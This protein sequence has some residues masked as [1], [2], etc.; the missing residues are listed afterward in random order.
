MILRRK[1]VRGKRLAMARAARTHATDLRAPRND[2]V[3]AVSAPHQ[4]DLHHP[5]NI[6]G[7]LAVPAMITGMSLMHGRF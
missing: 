1:P 5:H 4:V 3:T 2:T 6:G 7:R